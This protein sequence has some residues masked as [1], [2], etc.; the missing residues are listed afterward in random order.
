MYCAFCGWGKSAGSSRLDALRAEN[1]A[2]KE[3]VEALRAMGESSCEVIGHLSAMSGN[4][5]N[6]LAQ[7]GIKAEPGEDVYKALT[8]L[9]EAAVRLAELEGESDNGKA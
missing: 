8:A 2:L 3:R 1:A 9:D 5:I 6:M 7:A 4:L